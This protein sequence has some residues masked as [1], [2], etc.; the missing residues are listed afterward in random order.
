[1]L[2]EVEQRQVLVH[3]RQQL[4]VAAEQYLQERLV[5]LIL[6]AR[7]DHRTD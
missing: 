3:E 1:M 4:E 2:V 5:L 6:P 7:R